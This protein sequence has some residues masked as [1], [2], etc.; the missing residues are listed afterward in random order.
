MRWIV[1]HLIPF[2]GG[3]SGTSFDRL[4]RRTRVEEVVVQH[5]PGFPKSASLP[6]LITNRALC[7]DC[8]A[9]CMD[10]TPSTVDAQIIS[11]SRAVKVDR[12][13]AGTCFECGRQR[14]VFAI[15]KA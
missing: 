10:A 11:L 7:R 12:Y 13:A 15:D 14:L 2:N 6:A 5:Q 3:R 4:K 9:A 1:T 8:I